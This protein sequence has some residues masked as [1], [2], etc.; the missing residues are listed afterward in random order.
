[1]WKLL[2]GLEGT[3]HFLLLDKASFWGLHVHFW[4]QIHSFV[5]LVFEYYTCSFLIS[6][7]FANPQRRKLV[8]ILGT[9]KY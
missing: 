6:S 9:L 4:K 2:W 3:F 7:L 5:E 1:M 8:K